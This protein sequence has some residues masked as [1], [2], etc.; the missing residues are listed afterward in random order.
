MYLL[1]SNLLEITL[2]INFFI[3]LQ[4]LFLDIQWASVLF[5]ADLHN[6][7]YSKGQKAQCTIEDNLN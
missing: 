7:N 2:Q 3:L 6:S 1:G 5:R 4:N